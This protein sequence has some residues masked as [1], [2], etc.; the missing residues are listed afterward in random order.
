M[1]TRS[2]ILTRHVPRKLAKASK[3]YDWLGEKESFGRREPKIC[4]PQS[5]RFAS[6]P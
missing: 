3:V 4:S 2:L 1:L 6:L 5:L